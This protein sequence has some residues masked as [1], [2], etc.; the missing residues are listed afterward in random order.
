MIEIQE[1]IVGRAGFDGY[2]FT[3]KHGMGPCIVGCDHLAVKKGQA[4]RDQRDIGDQGVG[5]YPA[6]AEIGIGLGAGKPVRQILA[7]LS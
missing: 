6:K 1:G 4:G 2:H 7:V 5:F 3:N